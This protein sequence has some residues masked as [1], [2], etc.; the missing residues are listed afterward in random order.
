MIWQRP[1]SFTR[2]HRTR[3]NSAIAAK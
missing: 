1:H 3:E 2:I